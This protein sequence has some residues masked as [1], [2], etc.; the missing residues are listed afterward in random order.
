MPKEI[1]DVRAFLAVA[2]NPKAKV[3]KIKKNSDNTYKLKVRGASYLYTLVCPD[4]KKVEKIK[5]AIPP[6]LKVVS[7]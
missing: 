7:L 5:Q 3:I 4:K 1:Q 2:R 6:G